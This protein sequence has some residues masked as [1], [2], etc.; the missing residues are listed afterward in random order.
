MAATR[1]ESAEEREREDIADRGH[2]LTFGSWGR[3]GSGRGVTPRSGGDGD[4]ATWQLSGAVSG[5]P[6]FPSSCGLGSMRI[7]L[8]FTWI[9]GMIRFLLHSVAGSVRGFS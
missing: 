8:A 3:E 6:V 4:L 1:S 5:T 7:D 2:L 9:E